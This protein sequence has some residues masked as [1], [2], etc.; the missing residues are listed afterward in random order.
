ML[1]FLAGAVVGGSIALLAAPKSGEMT[2]QSMKRVARDAKWKVGDY[3][4]EVKD[5][6]AEAAEKVQDS[7]QAVKRTVESTVDAAKKSFQK[8]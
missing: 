7:Y 4:D 5:T 1:A 3:C 2:R 8:E 6:A